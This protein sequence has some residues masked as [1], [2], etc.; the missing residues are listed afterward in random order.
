MKKLLF[1]FLLLAE[2]SDAFGQS[3]FLN[4][5][6]TAT[7]N[8]CYQLT[9]DSP[10]QNGTVWYANQIDLN[11]PFDISFELLL[12]YNDVN[13]ADGMCF[14]LHTQGTSAI[15][16]T[17]GGMGYLNFG[18]SLA[19]EF[20]TYQNSNPY[21]DPPYDHIAVHRNGN[22]NHNSA[23]SIA[24]PVQMDAFN[25]NTEDGQAHKVRIVWDPINHVISVYFN[26]N[27]RIQT[28][29]DIMATV[30]GGQNLVNWGFTA[31]T[32]GQFNVQTVCLTSD[33]LNNSSEL[34]ICP[35]AAATL[36]LN[37]ADPAGSFVWSP[38]IALSA[39]NIPNPIATPNES[40][41]YHVSYTDLCGITSEH[42]LQVNLEPLNV[43]INPTSMINCANPE[44]SL[45]STSNINGVTSLWITSGGNFTSDISTLSTTVDAPGFYS[46][47]TDFQGICQDIDTI[48][49]T[50]NYSDFQITTG[51][52]QLLDCNNPNGNLTATVN[53]FPNAAFA[54][55]TTDG[56]INGGS[57]ASSINVAAAGTYIVNSF[58]NNN[59]FDTE[60]ITVS[61]DYSNFQIIT[62]GTTL[63]NC[64][65]PNDN[66]SAIVNGFPNATFNW[67]TPDGTIN[68]GSNTP[69]I[70]VAAAGTYIVNSVLNNN[71]FDT[72]T[73][74]VSEDY[75]DFQ[76]NT[77]GTLLLNCSNPNDNLTANVN[78]FPNAVFN[79]STT[80]GIINGGSASPSINVA[81]AGT[82]IVNSVLNNNC[83]DTESIT[84]SADYSDFQI[85]TSGTILLSCSNPN[86]N[87]TAIVNGFPNAIFNWTT[88]DGIINGGSAS[89]SI[90]VSAAGTYIVNSVLNSNCSDSETITVSADYSDFQ[91]ITSGTQLLSCS[92]PNSSLFAVVNGISNATF[93]WT[94]ADGTITNGANTPSIS[95]SA[96]GNYTVNSNLNSNCF[97]SET[98]T[99]TADYSD[100]QITTNGDLLLNCIDPNGSLSAIV[101]GI[102]N[103]SFT[104]T[105]TNGTINGGS[106]GSI[107]NVTDGGTYLVNATL[108]SNC[109][110]S[111]T[112]IV[113]ANFDTPSVNLS[114]FSG[115]NCITPT[116]SISS[117]TTASNPSY[118]WT[119]PGIQSGQGSSTITIDAE[120]SYAL[121]VIDNVN[122]CES[123][124]NIS[125]AENFSTPS[126]TIGDQD[127][128]NCLHPVIPI[129]NVAVENSND[130]SLFWSTDVGN[131]VAGINSSNP[132]VSASGDYTILATDNSSG[133]TD[134]ENIFIPESSSSQFAIELVQFP[135]ILTVTDGDLLNAC[136]TPFL[137]GLA[138]S[139]LF[140]LL[141]A[142][143]LK[144]YS[145]WGD[146]IF[147]TNSPTSFCPGKDEFSPGTYFY[148]LVIS[149][150]CG[151]VENYQ[152]SGTILMK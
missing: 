93:T 81:A 39:T 113:N 76:I 137:P 115:L 19:V 16:A 8:D 62:G 35:G 100:F 21:S 20:D 101:N 109:F 131:L 25:A 134:S 46:I 65:D 40:T 104:W 57:T 83:F 89:P 146:L 66:L 50:D 47:L 56:T 139:E 17:G 51:G 45:N 96:A 80:D 122:G 14:V 110:D 24:G 77:T 11:Q 26:C 13:G 6:A 4:G 1:F 29:I 133:C 85:N 144:V 84:V 105:T 74:I 128:L 88:T 54:W 152:I 119:G 28:G 61:A 103:A 71:C 10:T 75:S 116:V 72:E 42:D 37:G 140:S 68:G 142:F 82:Y 59:C 126:I 92:N 151:G 7:G 69:S 130:Y 150:V 143:N 98:I 117:A 135:N 78:G 138:Q 2:L 12:G 118:I 63:L 148:T 79:W 111:E 27:L 125:V 60:I 70:N 120:G 108:N 73:I 141:N 87:L 33:I 112:I 48:T 53:G 91:I 55:I 44:I 18:T 121:S 23:N 41:L 147:E 86:E 52:I 22:V 34:T 124:A 127:T 114:C 43:S 136:W 90:T 106:T 36:A 38:N 94:T 3:Y 107:I 102:P 5:S 15:G 64:S 9:P 30:F 32:G 58:L 129:L 67:S 31:G 49:I 132:T 99:V 95:V 97:D 145:R 149:S 123:G